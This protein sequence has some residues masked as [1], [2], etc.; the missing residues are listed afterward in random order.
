[1]KFGQFMSYYKKK[2][3]LWPDNSFQALLCLQRMKHN[4]Y[5][6]MKFLK[7]ATYIRYVIE[8]LS[9][10]VQISMLTFTE[11]F[12]EDFLKIKKA[13]ELVSR[14]HFSQNFSVKKIIL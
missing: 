6:G 5:W 10:F 3:K 14:P 11:S 12:L 8:N 2:K 7:Q 4:F 9:K 13:L 1:M